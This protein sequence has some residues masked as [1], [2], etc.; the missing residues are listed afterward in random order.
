MEQ[1]AGRPSKVGKTWA[2]LFGASPVIDEQI[3]EN[4]ARIAVDFSAVYAVDTGD[5]EY[6][7]I[8]AGVN[9]AGKEILAYL[10][11]KGVGPESVS[12]IFLT[13]HHADH[14]AALQ[15]FPNATVYVG[16][17]ARKALAG[18][19][20]VDG[21]IPKLQPPRRKPAIPLER[22][23][24]ITGDETHRIGAQAVRGISVPGHTRGSMVYLVAGILFVGDSML[25]DPA[26]R[27]KLLPR[28]FAHSNSQT[29]DS[30]ERLARRFDEE[31]ITPARVEP[32]HSQSG[33]WPR[34]L[35]LVR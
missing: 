15:R 19:A 16:A 28:R 34:M 14:V 24:P 17:A 18:G 11:R 23:K 35:E 26:G 8:D 13:H 10:E 32:S 2:R 12:A 31:G 5:R 27:A 7:L 20:L 21:L 6:A 3:T 25:F 30:L 1:H 33:T 4:I 9:S 22:L 29:R